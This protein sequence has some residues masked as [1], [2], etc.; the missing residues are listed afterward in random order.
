MRFVRNPIM[1]HLTA[2]IVSLL[3]F[4]SCNQG[5]IPRG[6]MSK[7][8]A[9]IYLSD[10]YLNSTMDM[11]SVADST[12]LYEPIF[13]SY[14]YNTD[15]FLRTIA[16]YV[17][18]PAKLKSVYLK[19]QESLQNELDII[20]V[21]LIVERRLDSLKTSLERDIKEENKDGGEPDS[22]SRSL[23]WIIF[24]E[25][26]ES[27]LIVAP[28]TSAVKYDAPVSGFWWSRSLRQYKKPFYQY[29]KNRRTI[30]VPR[31]LEPYKERVRNIG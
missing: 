4:A 18:R 17:E 8:I 20:N 3:L 7:I 25:L 5:L 19:A 2:F 29:E 28:D 16:Y 22:R 27:W 31:K 13:N 26:E 21:Q 14:G 30:P 6:K 1:K 15:D 12:L 9:D 11:V 10:K 24:P 23:R